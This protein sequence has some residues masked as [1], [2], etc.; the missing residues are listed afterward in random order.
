[1]TAKKGKTF[2]SVWQRKLHIMALRGA[3][4]LSFFRINCLGGAMDV[5]LQIDTIFDFLI[6]YSTQPLT[7]SRCI[8]LTHY[9]LFA[10]D[11]SR[12]FITCEYPDIYY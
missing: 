6:L 3:F 8:Y 7:R 1:M 12:P 5:R 11:I 10:F 4:L 2:F 9:E